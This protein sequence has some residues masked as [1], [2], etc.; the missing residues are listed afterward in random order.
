MAGFVSVGMGFP[1]AE[2]GEPFTY[3]S[4]TSK[5]R[6]AE[7]HHTDWDG[8]LKSFVDRRG[9]VDYPRWSRDDASVTRLRDYLH[10]CASVVRSDVVDDDSGAVKAYWI[11][12]YNALTVD[13]ILRV[14]PTDSIRDHTARLWGYNVWKDH[15][16]GVGDES[17]SLDDIEHRI[18]RP[19]QDPR[20]HFV[21]VCASRSCPWLRRDAYVGSRID[22]QLNSAARDFLGRPDAVQRTSE[23][24]RL[25]KI[26]DWYREDFGK[27]DDV[28]I[29]GIN[30]WSGDA[31]T[32][33]ATIVGYL[34]Y[35]WS[36]NEAS[37][38]L[39][40]LSP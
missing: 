28:I 25:S 22:D 20:I 11:N 17:F 32:D 13:A 31:F 3:R 6:V 10:R 24:V 29:R 14:Y 27:D 19:M 30:R 2:A 35:D 26:F 33:A 8:L 38:T 36:L 5:I 16:I 15:R 1:A 39:D 7:L 12:V 40:R 37:S 9:N 4:V 34:D 21:L 18:L 23:G